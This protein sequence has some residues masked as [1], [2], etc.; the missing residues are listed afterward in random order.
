VSKW[1]RVLA[2]DAS[3]PLTE[4]TSPSG[5]SKADGGERPGGTVQSSLDLRSDLEKR[6]SGDVYY[7]R[8]AVRPV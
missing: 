1:G 7:A 4:C 6:P 5:I 2:Q 3:R 8:D